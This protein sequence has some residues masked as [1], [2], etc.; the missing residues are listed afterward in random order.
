MPLDY[1]QPSGKQISLALIKRPAGDPAHRIGSLFTNPGGPG[2]SGVDFVRND[3]DTLYSPGVLAR[4]DVIGFDPRGVGRSTAVRCFDGPDAQGEFLGGMPAFPVGTDEE[5]AYT[6][7][8]AEL[9]RRCRARSC[10]LLDHLSTANAARD[11]DRL[12]EAVGDAKLTYIG[13]SYGTLLGIAYAN[14][15]PARVRA[16]ALD[17][18]LDPFGWSQES[19]VPFSLRV[20]RKRATSDALRFFLESCKRAGESSSCRRRTRPAGRTRAR[21]RASSSARSAGCASTSACSGRPRRPCSSRRSR[22]PSDRP[23]LGGAAVGAE[24]RPL[25]QQVAPPIAACPAASL[26][27]SWAWPIAPAGGAAVPAGDAAGRGSPTPAPA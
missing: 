22:T 4:F 27:V 24:R 8:T 26:R 1:D 10:D 23:I 16:I 17:S 13:H 21:S 11:L 20:G 9:G 25:E 19:A 6:A 2:N 5:R 14:L 18:I 15:F 3:A 7:A 12:R